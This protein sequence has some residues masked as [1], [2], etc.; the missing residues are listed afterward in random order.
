M[1]KQTQLNTQNTKHKTHNNQHELPPP[2]PPAALHSPSMGRSAALTTHGAA[3]S[4]GPMLS[5]SGRV[6]QHGSWFPCFGCQ[7]TNHKKIGRWAGAKAFGGHRLIERRNNQPSIG[8]ISG[9]F[10]IGGT[11]GVEWVAWCRPIVWVDDE[12]KK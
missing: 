6:L 1:C 3:S 12:T 5:A 11:A 9:R 4:Y 10:P 2:Y 8:V 7:T